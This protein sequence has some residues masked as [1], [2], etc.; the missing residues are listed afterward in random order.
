MSPTPDLPTIA[1]LTASENASITAARSSAASVV[2]AARDLSIENE[3]QATRAGEILRDL[4]TVSRRAEDERLALT[5]PYRDKAAAINDQYREPTAMLSEA[6]KTIRAKVKAWHA[7]AERLRAIEQ[8]RLD[9][10]AERQRKADEAERARLAAEAKAQADAWAAEEERRRADAEANPS[11]EAIAA[12]DAAKAAQEA[13][14]ALEA[15]R[16]I[17]PLPVRQVETVAPVP[18]ATQGV[19]T[20]RTWTFAIEDASM[21]PPQWWKIDEAAI[22]EHMRATVKEGGTP[23][24][25]GVRFYQEVG[26]SVRG[27]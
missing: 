26:M 21:V 22:R 20:R 4:K 11:P 13:M 1:A 16:A 7:E 23:E 25:P 9:A 6:D 15:S 3:E 5:K 2:A 8:A 27:R 10:E 24:I 17:T 12:A 19:S 18:K 14:A